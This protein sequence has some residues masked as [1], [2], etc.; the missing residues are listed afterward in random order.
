VSYLQFLCE[1]GLQS[2]FGH[3]ADDS[4]DPLACVHTGRERETAWEGGRGRERGRRREGAREREGAEFRLGCIV[5]VGR[6]LG[7]GLHVK[8]NGFRV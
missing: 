3:C 8:G 7:L 2:G 4:V 1:L 5:G 6:V